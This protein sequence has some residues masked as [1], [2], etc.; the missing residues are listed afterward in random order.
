LI[1]ESSNKPAS[2][3]RPEPRG[4]AWLCLAAWTLF[5]G[6]TLWWLLRG[7]A[8]PSVWIIRHPGSAP[9]AGV[10]TFHAWFT[11]DIG[12]QRFYPWIL[13]GPYLALIAWFFPLERGRLRLNLLLNLAVC[14]AF[15]AA[16]HVINDRT[17]FAF[18][19]VTIAQTPQAQ[20][21][22]QTNRI[23][24]SSGTSL[25]NLM[26]RLHQNFP[27]VRPPGLP[28]VSFWSALLDL[29]AYGAIVGLTH[30]VHFYR[31]FRERERRALLLE[32]NLASARLNALRAQLQPHFLFNSLNAIA[33][34][35]RRDPRLAETTL[36]SLSE[37]LR[38]AM[39]LSEKPEIA[40]REELEFIQRYLEIQQTRF[41]DKLRF[42]QDIEPAAQDCL[43]PTL[44]LQPLIENAI[45]HG[46]EPAERAG[47]VRLTAHQRDDKLIL[48]VADDGAGFAGGN[49]PTGGT[50][51]GLANLRARLETLY[52]KGQTLELV[53]RPQGG[54]SVR[55]EIPW[56]PA[57]T[58]DEHRAALNPPTAPL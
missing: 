23:Q 17:R 56:R 14:A 43:V 54:V 41:G 48:T 44:L 55:V 7:H 58:R 3:A 51:I 1:K 30:S 2:L 24:V 49:A 34:L 29:L 25:T 5:V 15:L 6:A 42:E 36:V 16:C 21:D 45:R 38:L 10:E 11:T 12:F 50:G 57:P 39:N 35:L 18:G 13:L 46:I 47:C 53:A 28:N 27:T 20:A 22:G 32:S 26:T 37:L 52:D 4:L 9:A 8:G 40:L 33:A 19:N 31:R